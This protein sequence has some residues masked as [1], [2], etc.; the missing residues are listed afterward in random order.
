MVADSFHDRPHAGVPDAESFA[1]H[2]ADERLAAGRAIECNVSYYNILIRFELDPVRR[3]YNKFSAGK[4][5]SEV[6]VTVSRQFQSKSLRDKCLLRN[7]DR[8]HLYT[9]SQNCPPEV[10]PDISL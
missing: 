2:T 3:A 5:F 7:S 4:A 1:C 10:H 8:L 9:G 6:V